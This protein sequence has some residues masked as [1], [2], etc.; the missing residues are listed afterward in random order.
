M[1]GIIFLFGCV[2]C[3]STVAVTMLFLGVPGST[4][5][6]RFTPPTVAVIDV[7]AVLDG[8][9]R[10]QKMQEDIVNQFE[11]KKQA[12]AKL[13][14]EIEEIKGE[15]TL[16]KEGSEAH[17]TLERR[18]GYKQTEM[19]ISQKRYLEQLQRE[20]DDRF[21]ELLDEIKTTSKQYCTDR[22][23]D[24]LI[25]RRLTIQPGMPSWYSI[26]HVDDRMEVT[27]EIIEI[28]NRDQ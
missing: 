7:E 19:D 27:N 26:F 6:D 13:N 21:A 15:M 23:I 4:A 2:A 8:M 17:H 5:E 22:G 28:L 24:L 20:R 12:L 9:K 11:A 1:R 16:V 14:D 10:R 3:V 25:Q 18:L